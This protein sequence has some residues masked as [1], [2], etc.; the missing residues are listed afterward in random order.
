M[1]LPT[2]VA[3]SAMITMLTGSSAGA[4]KIKHVKEEKIPRTRK[5]HGLF[6]KALMSASFAKT[7]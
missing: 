5:T 6:A 2:I 4:G 7:G 1:A 3:D